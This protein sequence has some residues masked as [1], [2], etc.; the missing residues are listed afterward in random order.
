MQTAISSVEETYRAESPRSLEQF[1]RDRKSMP[2]GA[3]GAYF[4]KPYPLTMQRGEGCYLYDIDER[5]FVDFANH[6]TAQILGHNHPAVNEA[7]Q[8]QLARGIALGAPVGVEVELAEELCDRVPSLERVRFANSGTEATLHAIRLARGFS[9]KPKIAKFEGGYHGSHDLVEVSVAPPLEKAGP[10]HAPY[11]VPTAGGIS[12]NA[13]SEVVVLPYNDEEAAETLIRQHRDELACVIFD[14]KAGI[15]SVRDDFA[16]FVRQVTHDNDLLLILDEVVAFRVGRGGVQEH[17]GIQP[18]LTT[19]GKLV[20]GGF[21]VGAL[22]GRAE[23]MD[24]FDTSQ[25][26]TGFFQSGTF[27]AHPVVMAAG[28]ATIQQLTPAAFEHL[29][30]LG[31]RL[32]TGLNELFARKNF[33]AQAVGIGSLFSIYCTDQPLVN[34]RV[35]ARHNDGAM[36]HQ[37]FLSLLNQGYFLSQGLTMNALSLPM[38]HEHVDGLIEAVGQAVDTCTGT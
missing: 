14:P 3:K 12:P 2:G 28:L 21:P 24:L 6:H 32:R 17:Y 35:G 20:G 29:N 1:E 37:L 18:D 23:L 26:P 36:A 31:D 4:Y 22:G 13:P 30:R 11:S 5:Q 10:D 7:V 34:F 8:A 33:A 19:Y 27:S 38:Q 15:L 16:R 25:G 9:G